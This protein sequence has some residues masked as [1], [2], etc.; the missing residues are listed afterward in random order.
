ME[1]RLSARDL[2]V[3]Q[4]SNEASERRRCSTSCRA[5]C[6][7]PKSRSRTPSSREIGAKI[8]AFG[9]TLKDKEAVI[10][11]RRL[12]A[13]QP[14]TLQEIGD[15]YGISR[16]RVR[17]IEERVKKKLKAYL[18]SEIK[19]L[20]RPLVHRYHPAERTRSQSAELADRLRG[21]VVESPPPCACAEAM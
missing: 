2:S 17:Q 5:G 9:D 7:R 10:F 1:Q 12:L 14:L 8:R 11:E 21:A 18:Q 13:E 6:Q 16:E 3:D 15:K 19:D 4:P 20:R